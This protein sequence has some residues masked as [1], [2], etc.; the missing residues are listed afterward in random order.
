MFFDANKFDGNVL[1]RDA[2]DGADF[3]IAQA[4]E[5]QQDDT[6]VNESERIDSLVETLDL[7]GFLIIVLIGSDVHVEV[8]PITGP[9]LLLV[10]IEAVIEADAVDPRLDVTFPLE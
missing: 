3:V 7:K 9:L 1:D 4:F 2:E 8:D 5:P 6:S 10:I